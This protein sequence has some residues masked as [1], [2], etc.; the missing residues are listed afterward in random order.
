MCCLSRADRHLPILGIRRERSRASAVRGYFLL[1]YLH[2]F[3]FLWWSSFYSSVLIPLNYEPCYFILTFFAA[4]THP[5]IAAKINVFI[6]LAP[7]AYLNH[8]KSLLVTALA[9]VHTDTLFEVCETEKYSL[10]LSLSLS[11]FHFWCVFVGFSLCLIYFLLVRCL[12]TCLS[13]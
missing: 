13:V 3:E 12:L 6:A 5:A 2:S 4:F 7:V 1:R 11:L 10:S 9:K 8:V